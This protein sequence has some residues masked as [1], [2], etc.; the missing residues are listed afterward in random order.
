MLK[1]EMISTLKLRIG[2]YHTVAL[3][4][5]KVPIVQRSTNQRS[6]KKTKGKYEVFNYKKRMKKRIREIKEI[7]ENNFQIGKMSSIT[8]T[9]DPNTDEGKNFTDLETAHKEFDKFIKRM[10]H[11][12][13]DFIYVATF[14]RQQNGNWHYHMLCNIDET[15]TEKEIKDIW[16]NGIITKKIVDSKKYFKNSTNYLVKNMN[17]V[18]NELK[19]RK[20]YKCSRNAQTDIVIDLGKLDEQTAYE[21]S[22]K[23]MQSKKVRELYQTD[24]EIGIKKQYIDEDT[25]EA[26]EFVDF[27]TELTE[28]LKNKGYDKLILKS[29]A[30]SIDYRFT[31]MFPPLKIASRKN[32]KE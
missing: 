19:G 16:E 12:F 21:I 29:T 1:A 15:I 10:N 14:S 25:G 27:N 24:K 23:I 5:E 13:D 26:E 3:D 28:E 31:E 4:C 17:S 11:H 7:C 8:F 2:R 30:Y 22:E 32:K 18:C 20:G 6:E 9:F